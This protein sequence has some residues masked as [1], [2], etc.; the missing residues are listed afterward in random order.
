MKSDDRDTADAL[1][2]EQRVCRQ[3][4]AS[5][6]AFRCILELEW[7]PV[8]SFCISDKFRRLKSRIYYVYIHTLS[9]R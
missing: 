4:V 9:L 6:Q 5:V 7:E 1:R 3:V 8:A 2:Q